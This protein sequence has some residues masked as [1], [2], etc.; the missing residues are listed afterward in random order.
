M[1]YY[2][3][4]IPIYDGSPS[5]RAYFLPTHDGAGNRV[6]YG[7]VPRDF[8]VDPPEMFDPPSG[9]PLIPQSEWDARYDEQEACKSSLEHL[10]LS[11][12]N[13]EPLFENLDQDGDGHCWAY[14]TGHSLMIERLKQGEPVVRL[15]PHSIATC[16]RTFNGGWCGK[17][18]KF[19]TE[20]GC[21]PEGTGAGEWPL[22]SNNTSLDTPAMRAAMGRFR[23][24]EQWVDLTRE[25]YDQNLEDQYAASCLFRNEPCPS[26]YPWWS[27]SVCRIRRVRIEA[28]SWGDLILNSWKGWGRHGLGVIRG[29]QMRTMGSL[30][31]RFV[32]PA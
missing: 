17:S 24:A 12:P 4:N 25:V 31:I 9:I 14:S 6:G 5:A 7:A 11:G 20:V 26:D 22:H 8:K 28:G 10:Y 15:N 18:A 13:G 21:A 30:A 19:A 32:N 2:K 27:H 23:I 3:G 29:S 1:D 16:L